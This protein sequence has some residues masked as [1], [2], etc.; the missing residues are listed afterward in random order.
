MKLNTV[1]PIHTGG[2]AM[3]HVGSPGHNLNPA[4]DLELLFMIGAGKAASRD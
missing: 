2:V 1:V 3:R 4:L